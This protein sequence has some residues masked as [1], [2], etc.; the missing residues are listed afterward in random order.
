MPRQVNPADRLALI[1]DAVIALA[2]EYGFAAV[3][4]RAVAQRIGASTTAVTHYVSSREELLREAIRREIGLHQANAPSVTA[5]LERADSLR[6]FIE[7]AVLDRDEH[8]HRLW[9]A[10]V[11]GAASDPVLRAELDRFNAWWIEQ[12]QQRIDRLRPA[13]PEMLVDLLNV[14]VDGLI[15]TAFDAGKPWPQERR[16][17]LLDAVWRTIGA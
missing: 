14:V 1:H 9:L 3:T 17:R 6:A 10:L 2:V 5:G 7:W 16:A 11:L 12:I 13:N 15:V 4:I 8:S